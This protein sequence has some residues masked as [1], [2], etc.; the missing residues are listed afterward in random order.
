MGW[1][2]I[3]FLILTVGLTAALGLATVATTRLLRTWR[4]QHNPLLLP[5]EI[6]LRL[7]L[8]AVCAGLGWLSGVPAAMLGWQLTHWPRD[9]LLGMLVGLALA[10]AFSISTRWVVAR[11][12]HRFYSPL[13]TDLLAPRSGGELVAMTL[14]LIPIVLLEEVLLRSLWIGG[15]A[16]LAA[17]GAVFPAG[18]SVLPAGTAMLPAGAAV[19]WLVAASALLFG[20]MHSAQG[21]WGMAGAGLAGL[22]FGVLFVATG[23]LLLPVVAH[24]VAD[25]AQVAALP[26]AGVRA[27]A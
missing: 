16:P 18:A 19:W 12:G 4:P 5:G 3:L 24:W 10:G 14:A 25:V 23:S 27:P 20:L 26:R 21:A 2:Y 22:L 8:I 13:L 6:A 1:Q 7:V 9:L 17:G 15:M 11:T